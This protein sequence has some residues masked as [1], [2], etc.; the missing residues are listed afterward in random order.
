[1]YS[2]GAYDTFLPRLLAF[3]PFTTSD[4]ADLESNVS[5]TLLVVCSCALGASGDKNILGIFALSLVHLNVVCHVR[6]NAARGRATG[7]V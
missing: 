1:M 2:G 6:M 4:A 3:T 5:L 7:G